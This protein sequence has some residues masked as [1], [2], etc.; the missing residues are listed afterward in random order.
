M[1]QTYR[2]YFKEI[3]VAMEL[4]KEDRTAAVGDTMGTSGVIDILQF[5]YRCADWGLKEYREWVNTETLTRYQNQA[6]ERKTQA[7]FI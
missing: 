3:E 7:I 6:N 4:E 5:L 2:S 1:I